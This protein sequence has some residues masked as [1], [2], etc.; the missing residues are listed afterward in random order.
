VPL[1]WLTRGFGSV[2]YLKWVE[3]MGRVRSQGF[4]THRQE[5]G[6]IFKTTVGL[7]ALLASAQ[8]PGVTMVVES[9]ER[10]LTSAI[11]WCLDVRATN[12]SKDVVV[13]KQS[14]RRGWSTQL[15]C[16]ELEIQNTLI[17]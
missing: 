10:D 13:F 4:G 12:A 3:M 17:F 6:L 14:K 11:L 2:R 1:S 8:A 9:V 15:S 16:S 5:T 7:S